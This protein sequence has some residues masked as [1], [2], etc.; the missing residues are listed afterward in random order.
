MFQNALAGVPPA[1][2]AGAKCPSGQHPVRV[3]VFAEAFPRWHEDRCVVRAGPCR[4]GMKWMGPFLD[5]EAAG[6][7]MEWVF[8]AF[9][10]KDVARA[11]C[12]CSRR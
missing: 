5:T 3:S 1:L 10:N 12:R 4:S 2:L 11:A 7:D 8:F 6:Q 9:C